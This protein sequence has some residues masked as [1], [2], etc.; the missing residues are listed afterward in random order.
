MKESFA[1]HMHAW[2]HAGTHEFQIIANVQCRIYIVDRIIL[3]TV[4]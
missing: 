1:S 4:P 2:L 3:S